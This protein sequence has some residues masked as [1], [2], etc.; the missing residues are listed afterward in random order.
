MNMKI[1]TKDFRVREGDEV[2]LRK[3]AVR[4]RPTTRG[5]ILLIPPQIL[6]KRTRYVSELL[7]F[8]LPL[9]MRTAMGMLPRSASST[10]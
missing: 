1:R 6:L 5:E 10:E 7:A 9:S 2:T 3:A 4:D 8:P